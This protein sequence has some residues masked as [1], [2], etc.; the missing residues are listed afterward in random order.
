MKYF[1]PNLYIR[2][3]RPDGGAEPG[4]ETEWE[5]AGRRYQRRWQKIKPVMPAGLRRFD[6]SGICLHDAEVLHLAAQQDRF[7][8]VL[9]TA[10]PSRELVILLFTLRAGPVIDTEALPV[11]LR[12]PHPRWLYEEFDL[13][14]R[15]QL[16]F[17]VLLSNGWLVRLPLRD[18]DFVV[19]R[20]ILSDGNGQLASRTKPARTRSA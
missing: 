16:T 9:Q 8:I 17:D 20:Q 18:F 4:I 14:R 6:D 3:N 13:D 15:K 11:R 10:P 7:V 12:A 19:G 2:G 5:R 1:T